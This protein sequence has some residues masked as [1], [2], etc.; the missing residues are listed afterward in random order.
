[1]NITELHPEYLAD[2]ARQFGFLGAFLGGVSATLFVTLLTLAEPSKV[3]RWA[4]GLAALGACSFIVTAY[5]SVGV[6][7]NSHPK[8]PAIMAEN[9][10][11]AVQVLLTVSF[12][13]GSLA[14]LASIGVSGWSR[15]KT[16]GV[17][18]STVAFLGAVPLLLD[19]A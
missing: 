2:L 17:I 18:T 10:I 13:I 5:M 3:V 9:S 11:V 8:A 19:F 14:L 7:A 16:L 12:G 1:M 4:I 15:S 6:I